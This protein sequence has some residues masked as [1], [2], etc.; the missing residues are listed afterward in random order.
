MLSAHLF[1]GCF[2]LVDQ[3]WAWAHATEEDLETRLA[4]DGLTL[5]AC[6]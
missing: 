5:V 6:E 4:Q 2:L 3:V 1:L